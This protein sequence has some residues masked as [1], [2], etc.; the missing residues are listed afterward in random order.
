MWVLERH[1]VLALARMPLLLASNLPEV[2]LE[3]LGG[4]IDSVAWACILFSV[5]VPEWHPAYCHIISRLMSHPL[6]RSHAKLTFGIYCLHWPVLFDFIRYVPKAWLP[7]SVYMLFLLP[8]FIVLLTS[9]GLAWVTHHY[10]EIPSMLWTAS[11]IG[12]AQMGKEHE[13][14]KSC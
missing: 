5:I 12:K 6:F 10:V 7:S 8:F 4:L 2:L 1:G 9:Y 13:G 3:V 11:L 14:K